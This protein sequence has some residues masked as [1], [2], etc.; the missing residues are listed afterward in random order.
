MAFLSVVAVLLHSATPSSA[1][2]CEITEGYVRP[3]PCPHPPPSHSLCQWSASE[4]PALLLGRNGLLLLAVPQDFTGNDLLG[5]S[6]KPLPQP[7]PGGPSACC[8]M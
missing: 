4:Q 3:S 8:D 7:C 1:A 6:G 2:Q 5:P